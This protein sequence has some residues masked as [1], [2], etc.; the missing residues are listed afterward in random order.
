MGVK[1]L[2]VHTS[3]RMKGKKNYIKYSRVEYR[4]EVNTPFVLMIYLGLWIRGLIVQDS[5]GAFIHELAVFWQQNMT[6]TIY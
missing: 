6:T 4:E 2:N 1:G 5:L 3:F